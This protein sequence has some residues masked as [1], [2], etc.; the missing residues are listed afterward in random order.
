ME[1][2]EE[3]DE[4]AIRELNEE[5]GFT[6]RL[7]RIG[8]LRASET[9]GQEFIMVYQ[10]QYDG[11]FT[12]PAEEIS[13][14]GF[15]PIEVVEKWLAIKPEDFAPGFRDCWELQQQICTGRATSIQP[16]PAPADSSSAISRN[17]QGS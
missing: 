7:T 1:A 13:A 3:D 8:K 15:F 12:F 14:V 6:T 2:N 11:P 9:T 5:L 4:A 16:L 17:N 10:G